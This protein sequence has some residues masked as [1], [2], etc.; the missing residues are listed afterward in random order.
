LWLKIERNSEG[1][2]G[3]RGSDRRKGGRRKTM[4]SVPPKHLLTDYQGR[5]GRGAE[6][7]YFLV[8]LK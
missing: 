8:S 3:G 7:V 2:N 6:S 5:K 4:A 1:I